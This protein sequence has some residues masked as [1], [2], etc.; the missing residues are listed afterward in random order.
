[1][2]EVTVRPAT[3]SRALTRAPFRPPPGSV[4]ANSV[5][6]QRG[7]KGEPS[8]VTRMPGR[9]AQPSDSWGRMESCHAASNVP[10]ALWRLTAL[11]SA[12]RS[13]SVSAPRSA[14]QCNTTGKPSAACSR[15]SARPWLRRTRNRGSVCGTGELFQVHAKDAAH[16]TTDRACTSRPTLVRCGSGGS[17]RLRAARAVRPNRGDPTAQ[18][19]RA[20]DPDR[21]L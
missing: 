4:A 7:K 15:T 19:A 3:S 10:G 21:L 2:L 11:E 9:P 16:P 20:G 1:M 14:P 6:V 12:S 18:P 17:G 5:T 13:A 8:R